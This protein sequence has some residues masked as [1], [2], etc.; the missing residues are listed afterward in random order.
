[1]TASSDDSH[2]LEQ[3]LRAHPMAQAR[4]RH[5][6]DKFAAE[7][8]VKNCIYGEPYPVDSWQRSSTA[9][10]VRIAYEEVKQ[11]KRQKQ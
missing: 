1:M 5:T 6:R 8:A 3:Q 2:D 11:K 4:L 7:A 10:Q 9:Q